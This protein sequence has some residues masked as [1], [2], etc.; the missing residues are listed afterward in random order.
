MLQGDDGGKES[1]LKKGAWSLPG[2]TASKNFKVMAEDLADCDNLDE[3]TTVTTQF[4]R[5]QVKTFFPEQDLGS[6]RMFLIYKK[7][8]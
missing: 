7:F 4:A 6:K 8:K 2:G 3:A 1:E 5:F